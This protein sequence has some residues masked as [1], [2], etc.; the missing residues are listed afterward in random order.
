MR[1]LA[2]ALLLLAGTASAEV[3]EGTFHSA[4]L[5]QD[6]AYAVW[7]PASY[8][9][10]GGP[11]PVLYLLHGLF[12]GPDFWERRGLEP[13]LEQAEA[14]GE[15]PEVVVVAVDGGDS[16]FVNGP[17]G[18][19]EDLA[20]RDIVNYVESSFRVVP[21]RKGRVLLGVSMGGYGALRIAFEHPR[22]FAA[23][24]THS[25]ML[26]EE[27]P[28]LAEGAGRWQMRAFHHAFG[29]PMDAA[30]WRAADPLGLARRVDPAAVPPL[31]FDCGSEDRYGL[32]AGNQALDRILTER[33]IPHEFALHP[34]DHG[35]AYV[36]SVLPLSLR[37]L[38]K[39]LN[40]GQA[41][42]PRA[43]TDRKEKP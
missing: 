38:G 15:M 5:G 17:E 9:A 13:I 11:Y 23:V 29:D 4:S 35:Y 18:R 26:L 16:F 40:R 20:T 12:E 31:Y 25:A 34:G 37:F 7:L 19:Y 1:K 39:V 6:V 28:T 21:G 32:Y 42:A 43:S 33:R 2:V 36:R 14:R 3:R 27:M 22:A 30:L 41:S 24:A 10:G 8:A